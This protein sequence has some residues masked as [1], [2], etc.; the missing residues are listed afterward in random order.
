[1]NSTKESLI[2]MS[3]QVKNLTNFLLELEDPI[4]ALK[5]TNANLFYSYTDIKQLRKENEDIQSSIDC[6]FFDYEN[7]KLMKQKQRDNL[8]KIKEIEPEFEKLRAEQVELISQLFN[9]FEYVSYYI[10]QINFNNAST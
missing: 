3:N 4:R 8:R 2:L 6:N 10:Q 9:K 7:K 1:M 5:E